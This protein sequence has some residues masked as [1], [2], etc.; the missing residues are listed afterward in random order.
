MKERKVPFEERMP[1]YK[2]ACGHYINAYEM[3]PAIFTLIRIEE[4]AD[5][6]WKAGDRNEEQIFR[7]FEEEYAKAHPQETEYGDAGVG[8]IDMGG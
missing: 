5:A 2:E 1:Q 6:C 8:M 3:D 4:A 7:M